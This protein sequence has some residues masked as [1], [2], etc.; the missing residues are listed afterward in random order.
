MNLKL[1]VMD[2]KAQ[3]T[4]KKNEVKVNR[5]EYTVLRKNNFGW[6]DIDP[7]E[8]VKLAKKAANKYLELKII[9]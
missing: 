9:K 7:G 3:N 5:K 4:K 2:K 1:R 6:G 8:K